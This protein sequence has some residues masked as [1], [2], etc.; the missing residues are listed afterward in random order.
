M[1]NDPR[2]T[3]NWS[4]FSRSPGTCGRHLADVTCRA[5]VVNPASRAKTA[6]LMMLMPLA[7][8]PFRW[9]TSAELASKLTS[10]V[11][12]PALATQSSFLNLISYLDEYFVW[13][14]A[15]NE[16]DGRVCI[17][18]SLN[19]ESFRQRVGEMAECLGQLHPR[20]ITFYQWTGKIGRVGDAEGLTTLNQIDELLGDFTSYSQ[21]GLDGRGAQM[22]SADDARMLDELPSSGSLFRRFLDEDIQRC[23]ST[24]VG[25][26]SFQQCGFVDD[27]SAGD[28]DDP[29]RRLAALQ[30][31]RI[32]QICP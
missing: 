26:Q 14:T 3:V 1:L 28:V 21:L 30:C 17:S 13:F 8:M 16:F 7:F 27:P 10:S 32:D 12:S 4:I 24:T 18:W 25:S 22:R 19:E 23:A 15:A 2:R 5:L 20:F 9:P 11:P 31:S 6:A 29:H